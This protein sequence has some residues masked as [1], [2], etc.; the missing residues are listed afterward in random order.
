[1]HEF[2][3]LFITD[4]PIEAVKIIKWLDS[5]GHLVK[6]MGFEDE[7]LFKE[8][9]L[10]HDLIL[11]DMPSRDYKRDPVETI[12]KVTRVPIV[13]MCMHGKTPDLMENCSSIGKPVDQVELKFTLEMAIN[14]HRMENA[15][16]ESENKY[17]LLIENANDP[18]IVL[19]EDG[20][21]LLVNQSGARYFGGIP[22]DFIGKNMWDVF[23][24]NHADSQMRSVWNVIESGKGVVIDEKTVINNEE[25]WFSTKIQ[26][27]RDSDGSISSVQLIARD[28]TSQKNTEK[29]LKEEKNFLSGTLNDMHTFVMVLKPTGE[30]IFVNN[31]PLELIGKKLEDV[32]GMLLYET[33]WWNYS[34]DVKTSIKKDIELCA[35]GKTLAHETQMYSSDGLMWI[36][37]QCAPNL[38]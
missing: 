33:P 37:L 7:E 32:E 4:D 29:D 36:R 24:K 2:K 12:K 34:Q 5:W 11:V 28:I 15:L 31:T 3:T 26:P 20:T 21:F 13:C 18:I 6:T 23:P 10:I 25:R 27:L 19:K 9:L 17:K 30:I 8:N 16:L 22:D 14:K 38:R 1:M 35:T